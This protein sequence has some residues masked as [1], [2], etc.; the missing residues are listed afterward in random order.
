MLLVEDMQTLKWHQVSK[1]KFSD[2][3]LVLTGQRRLVKFT[4][5]LILR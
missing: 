2:R 5:A 4:N 3:R 1:L